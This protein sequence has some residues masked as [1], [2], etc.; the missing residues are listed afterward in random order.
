MAKAKEY[1]FEIPIEGKI[2]ILKTDLICNSCGKE[3]KNGEYLY[4]CMKEHDDLCSS[5]RCLKK[6]AGHGFFRWGKIDLGLPEAK[7][8]QEVSAMSVLKAPLSMPAAP[9]L[10]PPIGVPTASASGPPKHPLGPPM[11][12][13]SAPT[14]GPP[15]PPPKG[16]TIRTGPAS[17]LSLRDDMLRELRRLKKIMKGE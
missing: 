6:H 1:A 2:H 17:L 16:P 15:C 13:P 14:S 3:L 10:P 8:A 9:P 5:Y 4:F 11:G 7:N 12:V